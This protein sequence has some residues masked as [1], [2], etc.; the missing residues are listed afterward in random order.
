MANCMYLRLCLEARALMITVGH[1]TFTDQNRS[2]SNNIQPSPDTMSG[3]KECGVS[4]LQMPFMRYCL[5]FSN[6]AWLSESFL[7]KV[8]LFLFALRRGTTNDDLASS[9]IQWVGRLALT[10]PGLQ[11]PFDDLSCCSLSFYGTILPCSLLVLL[12]LER[13][14]SKWRVEELCGSSAKWAKHQV[15]KQTLESGKGGTRQR[16]ER[17]KAVRTYL[18]TSGLNPSW[19]D[20]C[21]ITGRNYIPHRRGWLEGHTCFCTWPCLNSTLILITVFIDISSLAINGN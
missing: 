13:M 8:R 16:P 2:V 11:S 21:P 3:Q 9:P 10:C 18:N 4:M 15:T 5:H 14:A 1:W 6:T 19:S 7:T 12:V 20:M 17:E